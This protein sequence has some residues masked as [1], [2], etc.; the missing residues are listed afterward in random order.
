AG[1]CSNPVE[2][3]GATCNDGDPCTAS[4]S[5]RDGACAGTAAS[6]PTEVNDSVRVTDSAG[7][8]AISWND[9]PPGQ[10]NVYRGLRA[11]GASWAYNQ[12]CL[13]GPTSETR[14]EDAAQPPLGTTF[15]YLVTR[16]A[17]CGESILGR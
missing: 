11:S 1:V 4:D 12:S 5:C 2:P 13:V 16:V 8:S 15:F 7:T 14:V 9:A 17:S 6:S 3:D 10:F